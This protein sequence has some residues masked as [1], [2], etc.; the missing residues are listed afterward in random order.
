[1][2]DTQ[3][4]PLRRPL[5]ALAARAAMID[6][7]ETRV[8]LQYYQWDADATGYLLLD[9]LVAAADR[10]VAV[11]LLVDDHKQR[12]RTRGAASL[13][14]HPNIAIRFFN[15]WTRRKNVVTEALE[16]LR[17]FVALGLLLLEELEEGGT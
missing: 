17:R 16:F 8:D 14:L 4:A 1:M 6:E 11:R 12:N 9:R 3:V 2:S 10:G 5:D 15:T 13:S 7:A